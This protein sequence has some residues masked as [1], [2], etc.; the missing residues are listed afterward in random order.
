MC[1]DKQCQSGIDHKN[2]WRPKMTFLMSGRLYL[3]FFFFFFWW[4]LLTL[5]HQKILQV[6]RSLGPVNLQANSSLDIFVAMSLIYQRGLY[7]G[8]VTYCFVRNRLKIYDLTVII[9][10]FLIILWVVWVQQDS[11]C[12]E[13]LIWLQLDDGLSSSHMSS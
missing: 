10:F 1:L 4:E 3:T 9:L 8:L 11:S 6:L 5:H 13:Y 2:G 12:L 7:W